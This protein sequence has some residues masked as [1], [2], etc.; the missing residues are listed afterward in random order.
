[1]DMEGIRS[2]LDLLRSP[3]RISIMLG[4]E[5]AR[6]QGM[7]NDIL[8]VVDPYSERWVEK[9]L[10]VDSDTININCE[11]VRI[12]FLYE[13][14]ERLRCAGLDLY[15]NINYAD[16]ED[17]DSMYLHVLA[18]C[19]NTGYEFLNSSFYTSEIQFPF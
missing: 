16:I 1:M 17:R 15:I 7:V 5:L 19:P 9:L 18:I 14:E 6:S 10:G 11:Y 2:A 4:I 12:D 13:L 3:F 8:S